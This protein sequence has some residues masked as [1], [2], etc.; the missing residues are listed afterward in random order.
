MSHEERLD[1]HLQRIQDSEKRLKTKSRQVAIQRRRRPIFLNVFHF[2]AKLTME[3]TD[4]PAQVD[5]KTRQAAWLARTI[6]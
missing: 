1:R 2:A 4:A 5:H 3:G 6:V